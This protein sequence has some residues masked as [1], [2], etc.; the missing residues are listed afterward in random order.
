MALFYLPQAVRVDSTGA[1]YGGAKANFYLTGTTTRTDTFTTSAL[2][3]AHDNPVVADSAGQFPAIYLNPA[4]TYRCVLTES[5]DT[6]IDDVDPYAEPQTASGIAIVD[7]GGYYAGIEVETALADIG[8]NYAKHAAT[9]TW[10]ADQTFSGADLKMADNVI[11]RPEIKDFGITHNTLTQSSGTVDIDLSTGNSFSFVLTENAT[12][13]LSNPPAS[14]TY[15][16]VTLR[17]IQDGAGGAYTVT[18]PAAVLWAGGSGPTMST[19]NDAVDKVTLDTIDGGTTWD[20]NY[21]Q[22]YS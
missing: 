22:A 4:T 8:A 21:A 1:P 16:Q 11:E 14:G 18:Y 19:G 17:I 12:L 13:T 10:T 6:Q 7:S 15:G 3:V 5:D 9:G 20:G 2:S